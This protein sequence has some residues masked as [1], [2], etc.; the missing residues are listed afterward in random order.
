MGWIL[1]IAVMAAFGAVCMIWALFGWMIPGSKG[2]IMVCFG[3][4]GLPESAFFRRYLFL[5]NLG[6]LEIPLIIVDRGL[7]APERR[8]LEHTYRGIEL[9]G[10]EELSERLQL[11]RKRIDG[12]GNGNYPGR[13][14]RRG[15]SEL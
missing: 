15:I 14:Q 3:T 11:E 2:G 1:C 13:D 4:P 6:L 9:C 5:R 8:K 10:S 12:A 7:S